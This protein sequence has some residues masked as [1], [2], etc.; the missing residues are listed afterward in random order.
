MENTVK[1]TAQTVV[2]YS[3][4][5]AESEVDRGKGSTSRAPSGSAKQGSGEMGS[6][7][8]YVGTY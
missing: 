8:W 7:R 3:V 2:T 4:N 6:T 5:E 1:S